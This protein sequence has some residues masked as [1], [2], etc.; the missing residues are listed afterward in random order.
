MDERD[1]LTFE[2]TAQMYE[3]R[4]SKLAE[5]NKHL[6]QQLKRKNKKVKE[7][8]RVVSKKKK[9]DKQHFRNQTSGV[10]GSVRR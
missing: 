2:E 10:K 7:L 1:L 8:Q 6:K 4:M 3:D 5:E 9:K